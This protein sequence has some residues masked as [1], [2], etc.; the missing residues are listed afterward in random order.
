MSNEQDTGDGRVTNAAVKEMPQ[1]MVET[2]RQGSEER[3]ED[4]L[5][6]PP[7][8]MWYPGSRW[9]QEAWVEATGVGRLP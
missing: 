7:G 9:A 5:G 3:L 2:V 1:M 8:Y 6:Q 4:R